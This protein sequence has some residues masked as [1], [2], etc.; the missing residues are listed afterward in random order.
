MIALQQISITT[1]VY[2]TTIVA[3]AYYATRR[4][5][6][7]RSIVANPHVYS[8]TLAVYCSSWTYYGSVG[9]AATS[10]LD[11]L[12]IYLGPTLVCF[13]W[14]F[15]LR[16]IILISKKEN[17]VSIADFISSR[18]GK[19]NYLGMIVTLFAVLGI[20]PYIALQLKAIAYTFNLLGELPEVS[21]SPLHEL[22]PQIPHFIDTAFIVA[23]FLSLF[24][25]LFGAMRLDST[26]RHEGLM[27]AIALESIVK[28]IAFLAVGIFVTYGMF[29]GF[30]DIFGQFTNLYPEKEHLLLIPSECGSGARWFTMTFMS[31]MAIMF[32]PRQFH[33]M[34]IENSDHHHIRT[35]MWAFPAYMFLLNLFVLPIA[36][37]GIITFNGDTSLADYF[38]LSM[39]L[40]SGQQSLAILVFIGGFSAA[41]G[42]VMLESVAS[43]TMILN[44]L[45]MPIIL[46]CNL[47]KS[48]ISSLLLNIKRIAIVSVIF[49]GY[50]YYR[51]LG[52][53]EA[54]I[55]IGLISFMA[56]TQFAPALLGG[57]YWERA[58]H[59]GTAIG[60]IMGFFVWI[61]TLIIPTFVDAGWLPLSVILEGPFGLE[62]LRPTALFYLNSLDMWSHS[63]FWTL[64][65]NVGS[66]LAFSI[67]TTPTSSE[68]SQ[69]QRF[70][71][72]ATWKEPQHQHTRISKAPTLMEFVNLMSKFI[73]EK[74]ANTAIAS[75]L[76][77][78]EI[79]EKGSL[80]E[81]EIPN[82]KLFT[83]KTLAASVGAAAARIIIENYLSA[84]GSKMEDVF[85][86]F[87]T[88]SL[89]RKASRE[90]LSVLYEAAHAV[91]S[92]A[93]LG[94]IFESILDL[95]YHQF[96]FDLCAIR[97]YNE[98]TNILELRNFRG[99]DTE[100][101]SHANRE[102]NE[103]TC[104][105]TTYVLNKVILANDSDCIDKPLSMEIIRRE[106]IKSFAHAPI[107]VE[108]QPI[109]VLS[110][111]SRY[112]KGI[113]TDEFIE[114]YK[115]LA[116]QIGIAW[117]NA[118]QTAQL[119]KASEHE[120][121]LRI[122]ES[123]QLG[124]LPDKMPQLPGVDIAA[125]CVPAKQVGGDYYDFIV[126]PPNLD[127][128]I[129]DVS[130]HNIGA[131]L[132]MAEARTFI[133]ARAQQLPS[134]QAI[135][136]VLNR[137]MH[138]DL[139]KAELF[140]TM[141]YLQYNSDKQ[142]IS[143]A[144]AGHNHPLILRKGSKTFEELDTEGLILGIIN[145]VTFEQ[146]HCP[147]NT[148]DLLMLYTDGIIEAE[149]NL[150]EMFGMEQL[151]SAILENA[152]LSAQEIIDNTMSLARMF[153]GRRHFNDDVTI[154]VLKIDNTINP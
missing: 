60:L 110:S 41:A 28:L 70:V 149:N 73:G 11:F 147:L 94:S 43:S 7:G 69:A 136:D 26:E 116:A 101:L 13:S 8:L 119:I 30:T 22:I 137:F 84:R 132:L 10:G 2:L 138:D 97:I 66:F 78:R 150:E 15:F 107:T 9:R 56:A 71:Q 61:Y 91:S 88:V 44:N 128:V 109:G 75:Y 12:T 131:A 49:L 51:T 99:I 68:V 52:T 106:G 117:R 62:W 48:D 72:V 133:Q 40:A 95:L 19:S 85:N 55:N 50:F 120:K 143:Y 105:G 54:L 36:L 114:L 89:S 81:H 111:Y 3:V 38:V 145:D 58:N 113:Y 125:I 63:L 123:I 121:E 102:I 127:I 86:I 33:A 87:G 5:E 20:V 39:P 80:S 6:Q 16:K 82:L 100:F 129:A 112:A 122:A 32:L 67:A 24:C 152:D 130:G 76:G 140:I 18:Y 135:L 23:I 31:M 153:Q 144:N 139:T 29:N 45:A 124:L 1:I 96:R 79:D 151:K 74:Q 148:G 25:I 142:Q 37:G 154:V 57:L 93:D 14:W 115:N 42:M 134:S 98:E 77:D 146:R 92:G 59:R 27:A 64:F 34:V 90:Q 53:S 83:E 104:I 21:S 118:N 47:K 46:R 17:I 108:G 35:A 65:F 103:E 4:R 126:Q 141:F